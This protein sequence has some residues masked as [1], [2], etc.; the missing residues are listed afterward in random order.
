MFLT[1]CQRV[2][3]NVFVVR[4][5]VQITGM[6]ISFF[7]K[8]TE[9]KLPHACSVQQKPCRMVFARPEDLVTC[10]YHL[11]LALFPG[12]SVKLY[13]TWRGMSSGS[14]IQDTPHDHDYS[15]KGLQGNAY[16]QVT[17]PTASQTGMKSVFLSRTRTSGFRSSL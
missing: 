5:Q 16:H 10:P 15:L 13:P 7:Q 12:Y 11:C 8:S 2:F 1:L 14:V 9:T 4:V 3:L 6:F 17:M